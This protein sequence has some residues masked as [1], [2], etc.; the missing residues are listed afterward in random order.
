[1]KRQI[2][3]AVLLAGVALAS[4]SVEHHL[5]Q[6]EKHINKAKAKGFKPTREIDTTYITKIDSVWNDCTQTF[7]KY[8][9][10]TDTV[11]TE[12]EVYKY[13]SRQER[14]HLR[15]SAAF[16]LRKLKEE[17]NFA[18]KLKDK[19]IKQL[20]AQS[21]ADDSAKKLENKGVKIAANKWIRAG[22]AFMFFF[23]AIL[24]LFLIIKYIKKCFLPTN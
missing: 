20:K 22:F 15:D 9:V 4:C 5:Q 13:M 8:S 12:R 10:I 16:A 24:V 1:M 11:Y 3:T 19:E 23:I 21:K 18:L 17:N 6:S 14:K 2:F 7:I